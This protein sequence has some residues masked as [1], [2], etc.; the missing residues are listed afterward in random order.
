MKDESI[1]RVIINLI[2]KDLLSG[3]D[4]RKIQENLNIKINLYNK[5]I[6][7]KGIEID[8]IVNIDEIEPNIIRYRIMY[9]KY[10]C[11]EI[12]VLN[13]IIKNKNVFPKLSNYQLYSLY[14]FGEKF[15]KK[16]K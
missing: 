13:W 16:T 3:I 14:K 8:K 11:N 7:E 10:C 5:S 9:I 6:L 2:V 12:N 4:V 1:E 15:K